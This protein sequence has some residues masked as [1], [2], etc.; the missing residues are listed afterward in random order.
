[1]AVSS[2][3]TRARGGGGGGWP[4]FG[5]GWVYVVG[6]HLIDHLELSKFFLPN[7]QLDRN[8]EDVRVAQI[9]VMARSLIR[10]LA[11]ET[12]HL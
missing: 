12:W 2:Y 8:S 4:Q 1:M 11:L 6:F 9:H 7:S 5:G 10:R 3:G